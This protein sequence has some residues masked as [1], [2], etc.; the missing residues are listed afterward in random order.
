M[1]QVDPSDLLSISEAAREKDCGRITL[2]RAI[3]D[4]RLNAV[5]AGGRTMLVRDET[6]VDYE[7]KRTGAR[8]HG[9]EHLRG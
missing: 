3:D 2:Y 8:V 1:P 4:G 7:P 5:E 9:N 6:Y